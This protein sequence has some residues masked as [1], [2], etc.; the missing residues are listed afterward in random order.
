M[1]MCWQCCNEIRIDLKCPTDCP[2][3]PRI[4]AQSPFPAFKAD[5]NHEAVDAAKKYIDIW[6]RM[7]NPG[8]VSKSPISLAT[9]DKKTLLDT[10]SGYQYPGNFPVDYLMDRLGL[11]LKKEEKKLHPED[12]TAKYL[13][14]VIALEFRELRSLTMNQSELADLA[15]LYETIVS[16]IPYFKKLRQYSF[17]H[18]GMSEDGASCIVFTELNRKHEFC[19]VL[20]EDNGTWYIRQ[21][22]VG[23][24]S[25]YFKQNEIFSSIAQHLANGDASRAFDEIVL[26]QRS[27]PD[28]A[29]L[30]YYRGLCRLLTK[31]QNRAKA[32][33]MYA[34]ALDNGFAP[35]YMHLGILCLNDKDYKEAELW[36]AALC[37]IEP[38]NPDSANNLGIALIGQGRNDEAIKVWQS[39][40]QKNASHELARKNLE[41]YG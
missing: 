8:F 34:V 35:P 10:L 18:T 24:P 19:F 36:F 15:E 9:K 30:Y 7:E 29:D 1:G 27:F 6:I 11:P 3:A 39:I 12:V 20:R 2:Y 5:N 23:N 41:L 38:D 37:R 17:V 4:E 28:S 33:L 14:F 13:D 16:E 32:D 26:A 40:L 25:L 31:E 21:C 22:I